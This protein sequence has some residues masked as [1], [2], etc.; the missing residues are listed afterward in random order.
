MDPI[1]TPL[2][3]IVL[4]NLARELIT[5]AC[6]DYLKDKLRS[7]FGWMEQLGERD[8][9]ELAY[10][11]AMEQAFS[12]CLEMLLQNIKGLGYADEELKQ[13]RSSIE[14]FIKDDQ[15]AATL[16]QAIQEPGRIDLPPPDL[17]QERWQA[18]GGEALPSD[19]LW[20]QVAIAFRR[21]VTKR[22]ILSD[23]LRK[24]LNA[25]NIQQLK[26]LIEEQGGV[27]TPVRRDKYS[28]R[29]RTKFSP[30]DLANLMP[31]YAEDPGK[32]VIQDVFV[33]Q[34][35][36]ENPPPVEIPKDITQRFKKDKHQ[37]SDD[38]SL[39][40]FDEQQI[41][42]LRTTYVNQSPQPV[43]EIIST[44]DNRLLVLT[45]EPGSGKSTLMRY[46]LTGIIEPPID[47][48]SGAQLRW[49]IAFKDAFPLL[50]ELR[51][52]HAMRL[53]GECNSFLEYVAYMGKTD[54]WSLDDHAVNTFLENESS[55][56]M[57]DGLDEI[58]D[59]AGR[60]R[61]TQE[62]AGFAQRYP[63]SRIVVTSRPVGYK[64]QALRDAGFAHFGLQDLNDQQVETYSLTGGQPNAADH[65][66]PAGS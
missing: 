31:A 3:A 45:G 1:A 48:E 47:S 12:A 2:L 17:L 27:K 26:K 49:T 56:V 37:M 44:A 58:F 50:I 34:N 51:D 61:V 54:H 33:A 66:V 60:Q 8:R 6:K 22:I 53:R 41:E 64:Q 9:I 25:Q 43:L 29:M 21:Q 11:D 28:Q 13:Y 46:L 15:V 63:H 40:D 30:V 24:L 4:G 14:A 55:L 35:V 5:D 36:R 20:N 52:F 59:S 62:I 19:T 32:M 42:K 39:E 10:Q 57:F 38:I 16:L 18:V 65:H 7:F 23:D